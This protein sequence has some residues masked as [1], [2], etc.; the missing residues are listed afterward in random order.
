MQLIFLFAFR[1][2]CR[3]TGLP[4]ACK[5]DEDCPRRD[6]HRCKKGICALKPMPVCQD[7]GD[8]DQ[9]MTAV[10]SVWFIWERQ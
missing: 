1:K 4:V 3:D 8:C 5:S 10:H 2:V 7:D 9:V 6:L